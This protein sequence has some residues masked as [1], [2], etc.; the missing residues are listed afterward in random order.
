[1]LYSLSE[2]N[3]KDKEKEPNGDTH[4]EHKHHRHHS[5]GHPQHLTVKDIPHRLKRYEHAARESE[6][7][8]TKI[9]NEI[10]GIQKDS[11]IVDI[12]A[13]TGYWTIRMSPLAK[14]G[15]IYACDI[16]PVMVDFLKERVKKLGLTNVIPILSSPERLVLPSPVNLAIC[17]NTYHHLDGRVEYFSKLRDQ[18][19]PDGRLCIVDYTKD[20][21]EGPPAEIRV[22]AEQVIQELEK[23]GW[24]QIQRKETDIMAKIAPGFFTLVFT[25]R[26]S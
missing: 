17:I 7:Q 16:E 9:L 12:G 5:H 20:A 23:A 11:I 22:P 19:Q 4:R 10:L 6:Q 21:P 15:T 24:M 3:H 14:D 8:V 2:Y 25:P 26:K 18:M 1:M 13:G